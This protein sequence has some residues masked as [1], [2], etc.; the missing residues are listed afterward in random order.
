MNPRI[1]IVAVAAAGL[2]SMMPPASAAD[3][4]TPKGD[5]VL[6]YPAADLATADGR[7]RTYRRLQDAAGQ[8][9]ARYDSPELARRLVHQRCLDT[10]LTAAIDQIHDP[11]LQALHDATRQGQSPPAAA[12]I[13][14]ARR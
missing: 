12:P 11:A 13:R 9:C 1:L 8:V 6:R 14:T 3:L 2:L 10:L 7:A 5:V 4:V